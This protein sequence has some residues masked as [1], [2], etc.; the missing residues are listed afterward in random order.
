[1]IILKKTKDGQYYYSVIAANGRNLNPAEPHHNKKDCI[2]GMHALWLA[3]MEA[4]TQG[5]AL[6]PV[7]FVDET[8]PIP[9]A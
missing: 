1:M 6:Y 8:N 4:V 2:D 3:M 5:G 7:A 9:E